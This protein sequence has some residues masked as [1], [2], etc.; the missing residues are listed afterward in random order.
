MEI[1]SAQRVFGITELLERILLFANAKLSNVDVSKFPTTHRFDRF[2]ASWTGAEPRATVDHEKSHGREYDLAILGRQAAGMR[3]LLCKA[4]RVNRRFHDVIF[5]SPSIQQALFL[6]WRKTRD[7][8][9]TPMFNPLLASK[10]HW[11]YFHPVDP[12]PARPPQTFPAHKKK[13]VKALLYEKASW[14][15]MFPV[16]PPIRHVDVERRSPGKYSPGTYRTEDSMRTGSINFDQLDENDGLRMGV[17]F[18]ICEEWNKTDKNISF[19]VEWMCSGNVDP[20]LRLERLDTRAHAI[21]PHI[22]GFAGLFF[23]LRLRHS[24]GEATELHHAT[25]IDRIVILLC[26]YAHS[27]RGSLNQTTYAKIESEAKAW[28]MNSIDW[29]GPDFG[30]ERYVTA[31]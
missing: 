17:L 15:D 16:L 20:N 4:C 25:S 3:W 13:F 5:Q 26:H 1:S 8:S 24:R 10:F 9:N 31:L 12:V 30:L 28:S 18:D 11:G 22:L 21:S 19:G 7:R 27:L 14:R 29:D 6:R 23:A 2:L